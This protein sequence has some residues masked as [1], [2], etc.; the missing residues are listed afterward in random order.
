MKRLRNIGL[1]F[2][3]SGLIGIIT[4]W[5]S[6][7]YPWEEN[8]C[9]QQ[10]LAILDQRPNA[11]VYHGMIN[12]PGHQGH[13]LWHAQPKDGDSWLTIDEYNHIYESDRPQ[14]N[15]FPRLIYTAGKYREYRGR[16]EK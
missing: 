10:A 13:C 8:S 15:L 6:I 12:D 3:V 5:T 16:I 7:A 2:L 9:A 1:I 4:L 14:Y 11:V